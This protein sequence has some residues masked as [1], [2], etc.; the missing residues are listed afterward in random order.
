M[1]TKESKILIKNVWK[2]KKYWV[3]RLIEEFLNKK[4]SK[5]GVEDFLKRLRLTRSIERAP[6][7]GRWLSTMQ[8][9]YDGLSNMDVARRLIQSRHWR[10]WFATR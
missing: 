10:L 9:L 2:S 4:W 5:R 7:S 6:G 1:L 3:T 8:M